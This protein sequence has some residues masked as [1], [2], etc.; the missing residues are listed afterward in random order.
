MKRLAIALRAATCALILCTTSSAVADELPNETTEGLI[1]I[2]D[3]PFQALY[4]ADGEINGQ[5]ERVW[6]LES[7][8]MFPDDF[9]ERLDDEA[10]GA[11]NRIKEADMEK[12]ATELCEDFD[13]IFQK[14]LERDGYVFADKLEPGVIALRPV[15][16]IY[17]IGS[18]ETNQ[19]QG[20]SASERL[21]V[22]MTLFMHAFDSTSN[23][24]IGE[25]MDGVA[26]RQGVE[27]RVTRRAE[28]RR[29]MR[30]W[31]KSLLSILE[32][33]RTGADPA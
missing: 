12:A 28:I 31:A 24:K 9:K 22:S 30:N 20:R 16:M 1:R 8:A 27:S 25:I 21:S 26:S 11:G 14:T 23:Q 17:E 3:A 7:R 2:K 10:V 4:W 5:Y 32:P 18:L 29:L 33:T 15:I 6:L 13:E 19:V